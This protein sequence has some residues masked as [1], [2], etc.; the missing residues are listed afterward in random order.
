MKLVASFGFVEENI[1]RE[2]MGKDKGRAFLLVWALVVGWNIAYV[3]VVILVRIEGD[4][5][6]GEIVWF[7][8]GKP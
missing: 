3:E 7:G 6:I 5:I 2:K 1:N 8:I 4:R